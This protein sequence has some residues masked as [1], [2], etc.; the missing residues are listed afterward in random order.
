[1]VVKYGKKEAIRLNSP[2]YCFF[3]SFIDKVEDVEQHISNNSNPFWSIDLMKLITKQYLSLFPLMS[4]SL[5]PDS[6]KGLRNNSYVE[7]YWKQQRQILKQV[8][9]DCIGLPHI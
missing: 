5:L 1:M 3:L 6:V 2:F 7:L 9:K 8:P 4:A